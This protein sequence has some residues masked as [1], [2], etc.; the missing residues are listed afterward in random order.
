[1]GSVGSGRTTH[2][3]KLADLTDAF[4]VNL[5]T[6][7][8]ES[9][10]AKLQKPP[11]ETH[12]LDPVMPYWK[13]TKLPLAGSF[14]VPKRPT[15]LPP[16]LLPV[17]LPFI[18]VGETFLTD[19]QSVAAIAHRFRPILRIQGNRRKRNKPSSTH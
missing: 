18:S 1:M 17:S 3:R 12:A 13:L 8:I 7:M 10:T 5:R 4:L 11:V 16:G 9:T 15:K 19:S 14:D 6:F 2:S